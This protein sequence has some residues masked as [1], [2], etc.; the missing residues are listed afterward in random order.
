M[1]KN[2][3]F[4]EAYGAAASELESLLQ[5]QDRIETRILALRKTM[6]AL[7]TLISQHEGEDKDFMDYAAGWLRETFDT[8]ITENIARVV[9]ASRQPL[10][11]SEIRNELKELGGSLAEHSNPLA[12]IHA[13]LGRLSE[14]GR[15]NETLKD[16]KKAWVRV[17][18]PA[19]SLANIFNT[20]EMKQKWAAATGA[21]KNKAFY[22]EK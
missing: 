14:S 9:N 3:S 18:R 5:E 22:G 8:S 7:S 2:K 12:T 17:E 11:A 4:V 20:P 16:G 13:I 15:V 21:K 19:N 10:T 1:G 6:N